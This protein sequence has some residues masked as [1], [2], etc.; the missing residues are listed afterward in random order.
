MCT[1][2][3]AFLLFS[4]ELSYLQGYNDI[5]ARFLVVLESEVDC[6]WAFKLYVEKRKED[7]SETGMIH[8]TRE[9]RVSIRAHTHTHTQPIHTHTHTHTY[10]TYTHTHTH[11][12]T[13]TTY[14]HTYSTCIRTHPHITT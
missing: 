7:F 2:L 11:T 12:H 10:T 3:H 5:A 14:T 1:L 8:R 6:Y 13:H 4:A 9:C